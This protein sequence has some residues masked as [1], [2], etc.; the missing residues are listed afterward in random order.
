[1]IRVSINTEGGIKQLD[2]IYEVSRLAALE[3]LSKAGNRLRE[4]SRK[5]L[6]Q[7]KTLWNQEYISGKRRIFKGNSKKLGTRI[8]HG[9]R[10]A[11]GATEDPENM[12][13]FI[14][15]FL[16][17][18]NL[19]MVVGGKHPRFRPKKIRDGEIKGYMA[20]VGGVSKR[21]HMILEK[22]ESG[23]PNKYSNKAMFLREVKAKGGK[24]SKKKAG[25]VRQTYQGYFFME[26]GRALSFAYIQDMMTNTLAKMI[27][28]Q[29]AKRQRGVA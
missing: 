27:E 26:K 9:A 1:M 20:S 28:N 13:S 19:T 22:L 7:S 3:A 23:K 24:I 8:S 29:M 10:N 4:N 5:S 6:L 16:M 17:E 2:M 14:N 15:S 25:A 21:T 12:A 18:K 11:K